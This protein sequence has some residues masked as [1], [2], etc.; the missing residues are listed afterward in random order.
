VL[1]GKTAP[2]RSVGRVGWFYLDERRGLL[3]GPKV[4]ARKPWGTPIKLSGLT[5]PAGLPGA[6]GS[7]GASGPVGP[8]GAAGSQGAAGGPGAI[9][10]S[11]A[12][13]A[14]GPRGYSVLSGI[15]SPTPAVGIDGD[16]YISLG[17]TQM[18]GPKQSGIWGSPVNLTGPQGPADNTV[19]RALAAEPLALIVGD[20]TRGPGG[21]IES[22]A[23]V[24]PDGTNGMLT[25]TETHASGAVDAYSV[26]YG[27]TRTYRQPAVTR[28]NYGV[29]T[30]R[31]AIV[32][33]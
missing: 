12:A 25:V 5:G 8:P 13:G 29:V 4:K 33:V 28:D 9:G 21:A 14:Q 23:V 19:Y 31:P 27:A 11:G 18:Y 15:G 26:T 22:A 1:K 7:A 30:R 3:Y 6:V 32:V 10:A 20:V 2:K 17:S 24:W 16:F